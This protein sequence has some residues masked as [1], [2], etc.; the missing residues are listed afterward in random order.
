MEYCI[1]TNNPLVAKSQWKQVEYY[2][3]GIKELY[4]KMRE[5]LE[6][7][8]RLFTHPLSGSIRP[9]VTPYK[10]VILQASKQEHSGDIQC[11]DRAISY[12]EGLPGNKRIYSESEAEDFQFVDYDIIQNVVNR[13]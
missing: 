9:D 3:C 4:Q 2:N 5:Q 11:L 12:M 8:Y 10:T 13:I 1:L 6:Q 7:G